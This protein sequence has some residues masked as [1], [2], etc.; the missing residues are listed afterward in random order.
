MTAAL[1]ILDALPLWGLAGAF[2]LLT[3]VVVL[4]ERRHLR[5][6]LDALADPAASAA[7]RGRMGRK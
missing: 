1:R 4:V 2:A 7:V 5:R 3:V 6:R